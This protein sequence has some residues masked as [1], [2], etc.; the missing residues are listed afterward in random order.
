M[1]G[2]DM[3]RM[4]HLFA[5]PALALIEGAAAWRLLGR[6]ADERPHL[7]YVAAAGLAA[8]LAAAAGYWGGEMVLGR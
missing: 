5:W 3:L 2:H 7:G 8:A 4:H 1:L 6:G